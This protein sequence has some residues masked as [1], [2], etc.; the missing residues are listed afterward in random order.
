MGV[1]CTTMVV[2]KV[3]V[4]MILFTVKV[5]VAERFRVIL[6][7]LALGLCPVVLNDVQM[8]STEH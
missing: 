6:G 7:M 3:G 8:D 4:V 2:G 1:R 5:S